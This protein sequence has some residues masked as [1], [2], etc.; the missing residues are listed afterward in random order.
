MSAVK[1]LEELATFSD[2]ASSLERLYLS[3]AHRAAANYVSSLMVNAGMT[4]E[5][6]PLGTIVGFYAASDPEAP[7]VIIGSHIDTVRNAGRFDG[8]LGVVV[9]IDVVADLHRQNLRLAF[10]IIVVA[11][12]D[13]EGVRFSSTLSGSKLAAGMFDP[14]ILDEIDRE[15]ITR[16][17]SLLDFGCGIVEPTAWWRR[18]KKI[19]YLEVH[20]EQGP[21][22]EIEGLP[23]GIVTSIAGAT[24]GT[25]NVAGELGHA[26]TVPM[27]LRRDALSAAAEMILAIES[28]ARTESRLVA[29]VGRIDIDGASA[30]TIPGELSFSLD[31]RSGSDVVRRNSW[32]RIEETIQRI[33]V[34]RGCKA[35]LSKQ[36]EASAS[37]CHNQLVSCAEQAI[38]KLGIT[39]H[40]MV[41]GAGHDAMAFKGV[42]PFAMIFVRCAG[43]KSHT[44]EECASPADILCATQALANM[45]ELLPLYL[46]VKEESP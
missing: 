38:A 19:A 24:R 16:I 18:I 7:Y 41:S 21:V 1:W 40:R 22:L 25:C 32:M 10:G 37:T 29:T 23:L 3:P 34:K 9:A 46:T 4:V 12:G 27:S 35:Q 20:I 2:N 31:V 13:E 36:H 15:G 26:G 33:A 17:Q 28:L 30:N 39:S 11:F 43:G 45:L 5:M 8:T 6:D 42:I 14:T 44:P